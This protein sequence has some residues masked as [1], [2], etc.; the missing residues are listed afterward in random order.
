MLRLISD[1]YGTGSKNLQYASDEESLHG[2]GLGNGLNTL[3]TILNAHALFIA[4]SVTIHNML[5]RHFLFS[6]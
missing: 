1:W 5:V 6:R 2:P 4:A 3:D